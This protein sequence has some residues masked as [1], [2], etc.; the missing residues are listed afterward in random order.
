MSERGGIVH[1]SILFKVRF[2]DVGIG[3][4]KSIGVGNNWMAEGNEVD[5]ALA[6]ASTTTL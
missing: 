2:F 1:D 3:I 5:S 4:G 6:S